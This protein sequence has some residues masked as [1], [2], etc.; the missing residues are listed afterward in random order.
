M[1]PTSAVPPEPRGSLAGFRI[2]LLEARLADEA[3]TLV[4]R[5]GGTPITVPAL[6]EQPLPCG[7]AVAA[8]LDLLADGG[9]AL[10]V[11]QTGVGVD[12]LFTE[13]ARLGREAELR[14]GLVRVG[15]V[16]RGPKPRAALAARGLRPTFSV[17]APYT[18]AELL[19]LLV[20][21]PL[22][23]VGVGMVHY[24]E[25]NRDLV[26]ALQAR[27]ARVLDLLLYEWRLPEDTTPLETLVSD[28]LGDR[29]DAVVFTTQIQVRHL[30][31]VA[32]PSRQEALAAALGRA[33]TGAVGPTCASALRSHGVSRLVVPD[34]P[35]LGP[36][37]AAV[38]FRLAE[39]RDPGAAARGART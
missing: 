23:N 34:N 39:R 11:L 3:A 4:R 19:A 33:V 2:A 32:G 9:L 15:T 27:G 28:V 10:L 38:A 30:F 6:R 25:P 5:R 22:R 37:F 36:L 20:P 8:F 14:A 21:V 24:G 29:L 31:E 16:A 35:K 26:E 7:P 1:S 12:A 18:S 13:A 17:A